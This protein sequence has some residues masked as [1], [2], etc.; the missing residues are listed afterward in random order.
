MQG[1][2]QGYSIICEILYGD[3]FGLC[4]PNLRVSPT[5]LP[6]SSFTNCTISIGASILYHSRAIQHIVQVVSLM[7][8]LSAQDSERLHTLSRWRNDGAPQPDRVRHPSNDP[9]N[10]QIFDHTLGIAPL[11]QNHHN[12]LMATITVRAPGTI[13]QMYMYQQQALPPQ[14]RREILGSRSR[15][16]A[17]AFLLSS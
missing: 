9:I 14:R 7:F 11:V 15:R 16:S 8:L 3:S 12:I 2:I 10:D 5:G 13:S 1:V 17:C 4:A 6:A